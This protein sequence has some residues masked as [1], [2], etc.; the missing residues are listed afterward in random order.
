MPLLEGSA[1]G[2]LGP[3]DLEAMGFTTVAVD[4]LDLAVSPGLDVLAAAGGLAQFTG[5]HGTTVALTR[6]H[7]TAD[8]QPGTADGG[9]RARRPPALVR[10]HDGDLTVRSAID[11]S[12][13]HFTASGLARAAADLGARPVEDLVPQGGLGWWDSPADDPPSTAFVVSAVPATAARAGLYLSAGRWLEIA[14]AT[15][16]AAVGPLA[17]DC[18]CRACEIAE[19]GYIGHLWRQHEI[20]ASHLLGWHN[21]HQ[22]RLL[23]EG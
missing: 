10:D 5:W 2:S 14:A 9:W 21:L 18:S 16:A 6:A 13:H 22:A 3:V 4:L 8:G 19:V 17:V 23:V 7:P 11:G 1:A 12:I 15:D 20:T